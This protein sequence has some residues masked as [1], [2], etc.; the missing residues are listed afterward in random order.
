MTYPLHYGLDRHAIRKAI[1]ASYI[2]ALTRR[3]AS[4]IVVCNNDELQSN[5]DDPE[6]DELPLTRREGSVVDADDAD[7]DIPVT[8]YPP[9]SGGSLDDTWPPE[10]Y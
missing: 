4:A 9:D 5:V 7:T 8:T 10:Y 1:E 3:P 2:R 6:D